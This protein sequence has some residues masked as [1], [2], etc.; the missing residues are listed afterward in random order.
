V[1]KPKPR[2][3]TITLTGEELKKLLKD[4]GNDLVER[5]FERKNGVLVCVDCGK[6]AFVEPFS[7]EITVKDA[8]REVMHERGL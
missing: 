2:A 6:P 8:I 4:F 3:K 1:V 5:L 7:Q